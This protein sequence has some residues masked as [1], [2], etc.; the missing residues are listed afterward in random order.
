MLF[1][2]GA[3]NSRPQPGKTRVS[4]S[5]LRCPA[6]H[7]SSWREGHFS[8]R[9]FSPP[10]AAAHPCFRSPAAGDSGHICRRAA[11]SPLQIRREESP[12]PTAGDRPPPRRRRRLVPFLWFLLSSRQLREKMELT[13]CEKFLLSDSF[14]LDGSDVDTMRAT[15]CQQTLVMALSVKE[16][17]D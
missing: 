3:A 15:F 14:N 17:E 9:Y 12:P 10:S 13:P 6:S 1:R 11:A 4:P 16:H 5:R 2:S 7:R 8:P